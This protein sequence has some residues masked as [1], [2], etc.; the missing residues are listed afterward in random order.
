MARS[1]FL[2]QRDLLGQHLDERLQRLG[3]LLY[4]VNDRLHEIRDVFAQ[5]ELNVLKLNNRLAA[6]LGG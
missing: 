2:Q 5:I 1:E 6:K 3:H 4:L